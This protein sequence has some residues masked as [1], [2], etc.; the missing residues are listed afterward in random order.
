MDKTEYKTIMSLLN[1]GKIDELKQY[2]DKRMNSKNLNN[3]RKT[4]MSLI[5]DDCMKDYPSHYQRTYLHQGVL[6]TY[7]GIFTKTEDGIIII[8]KDSNLFQ[9]YDESILNPTLEEIMERTC[10]LGVE[11]KK[12][13][14]EAAKRLLSNTNN[15]FQKEIWYTSEDDEYIEAWP[16]NE[17]ISTY[18]PKKY[19][20]IAHSLLGEQVKEYMDNNGN[21]I[22]L[23][24]PNGKALIMR[25]KREKK[26][27]ELND[28]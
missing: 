9:L 25:M 7:C 27:N 4:I 24:S 17:A 18:V 23:K 21:G 13:R 19:Y 3:V 8:H 22:Y 14:L 15:R 10:S 20:D 26:D 28:Q 11:R 16:S 1:E 12:E 2:L 5:N 6:K